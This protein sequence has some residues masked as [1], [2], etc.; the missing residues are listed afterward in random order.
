MDLGLIYKALANK[1][2]DMVAGNSTDGLIPV[3]KLVV[4]EDDKKYFPP[5]EAV[6]IFNQ[7]TLEKYPQLRQA[8]AQLT[9]VISAQEM[10]KM[11]YQVD[12]QS[13]PVEK[14]VTK[15]LESKNLLPK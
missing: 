8:I 1:Q 15:F 13:L 12:N 4:L 14:V 7:K 5:Y 11:N 6:P 10:Q 2:V 9:G 3:L